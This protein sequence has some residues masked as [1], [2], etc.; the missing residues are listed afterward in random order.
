MGIW[1]PNVDKDQ[2]AFVENMTRMEQSERQPARDR[3]GRVVPAA[4]SVLGDHREVAVWVSRCS[5]PVPR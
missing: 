2:Q 5:V 1:I 3:V 4:L